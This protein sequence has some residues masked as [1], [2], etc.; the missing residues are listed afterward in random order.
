MDS[1]NVAQSA[2]YG[3]G[4]VIMHKVFGENAGQALAAAEAETQRLEG[5][6]SR[7]LPGSDIGRVNA[8]AGICSEKVSG[9]TFEVLSRALEISKACGG[10]FDVTVAP[11]VDLWRNAYGTS[12][13]PG[14]SAIDRVLPLVD[15]ESLLLDA[16]DQTAMLK[17]LGQ[18]VDLGGVGKGYAADKVAEVMREYGIISAFTNFGGNVVALGGKPD[19]SPWRIGIQHPRHQDILIGVVMVTDSSVVTSGDYQRFF[20]GPDG[21]R[22]H[23][24]VDPATGY[25]SESGLVSVTVIAGRS[26]DADALSTA[27]FVAGLE[28][29][30]EILRS[31]PGVEAVLVDAGL[32]MYATRGINE[33]FQA[34]TGK[35]QILDL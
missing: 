22:Y 8:S 13:P 32:H 19:G 21:K 23:H 17:Y 20:T 26:L 25:P 3:M 35:V 2:K 18:S 10:S 27:V 12:T 29:G 24:I 5:L 1:E 11:L 16:D 7:F 4:T 14:R 31:F 15:Y 28:R 34:V 9:E 33:C 6:L 30:M